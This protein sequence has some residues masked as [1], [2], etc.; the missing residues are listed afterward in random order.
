MKEK[1]VNRKEIAKLSEDL[2]KQGKTV[3]TLNGSFDLL[4]AGHLHFLNSAKEQGDILI[5]GL[6][7]DSSIKK[8]KSEDRPI[9][10][11]DDRASMLAA[12]G[13]VDHVVIFDE[14][15]PVALLE[16]IKPNVH[17]NGAEYGEECVEAETVKKNGGRLH[18][19]GRVEGL[20]TTEIVEK[21]KNLK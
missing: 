20:S 3:V 14:T 11:Q 6:N 2:K 5:V 12:L 1:I 17:V 7:S 4:H 15:D 8:Y 10:K 19:I 9:I 18:L 13:M 16:E 21:I